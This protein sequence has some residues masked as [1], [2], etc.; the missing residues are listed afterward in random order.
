MIGVVSLKNGRVFR[1][2][3]ASSRANGRSLWSAGP[4][5]L[6]SPPALRSVVF[7]CESAPGNS[8]RAPRSASCSE[9]NAW[10]FALAES[11][12]PGQLAVTVRQRRREQLEVVD[13]ARDVV[14]ARDQEAGEALAVA[15]RR[16]E[17]LERLAQVLLG[18]LLE[19]GARAGRLIV[20]RGAAR[21]QQDLQVGARVAVERGQ[22]LV[23]VHV[24]QRVREPDLAALGQARRRSAVP[25][26]SARNMSFRPVFGPQQHRRVAVDRRVLLLDPHHD[27]GVAVLEG[28]VA[29]LADL[30]AGDVHRLALA[31]H[32]RL[33]GRAARP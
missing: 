32:D 25:G 31:R 8:R 11:T 1:S 16:L 24:G 26:S 13:D 19:A 3:G 17:P 27:H 29:H 21:V 10:K 6:A 15:G 28:H 33:G 4:S 9:A 14:A 2:A 12:K 5:S 22:D 30:H 7:V 18:G 20:E 23:G